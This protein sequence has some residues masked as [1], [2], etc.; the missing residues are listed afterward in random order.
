MSKTGQINC[1]GTSKS[2]GFVFVLFPGLG[3]TNSFASNWEN[4]LDNKTF[5]TLPRKMILY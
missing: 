1:N 3:Q 4:I 5:L 2:G